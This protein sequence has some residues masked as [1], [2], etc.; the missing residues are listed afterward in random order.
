MI[1]SSLIMSAA[2]SPIMMVGALVPP[3]V[4]SGMMEASATLTPDTP[5]TLEGGE[6]EAQVRSG[7]VIDGDY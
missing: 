3:E 6:E 1:Q 7:G 4:I 5:R 2:F